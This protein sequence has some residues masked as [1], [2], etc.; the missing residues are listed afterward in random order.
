MSELISWDN[1]MENSLKLPGIKVNRDEYLKDV[2][3]S[4]GDISTLS[5]RRPVDVFG[6]VIIDKVAKASIN[7]HLLGVTSASAAAGIP[8]GFA[9]LGT[10][11]ADLAQYYYHV[12]IIAQKLGY[13]Y[14]WPDLLDEKQQFSE[15]SRNILTLFVGVMLGAGAA[16]KAV[17]E[18]GKKLSMQVA[19]R[20]PQQ[21]LTKTAYYPIIKQVGKWIGM[22]VTKETFAKGASKFIP[23]LGGVLSGGLT[24]FTFKPMA[25]KL[26]AKLKE[27]ANSYN[28]YGSA[29]AQDSRTESDYEDVQYEDFTNGSEEVKINIEFVKIQALIN[30]AK[31]DFELHNQEIEFISNLVEDS[32]LCDDEKMALVGQLH[33]KDL[34]EI[35]LSIFLGND[36]Y[37]LTLI[38]S[39]ASLIKIDGI[40]KS[41]E[42][43]YFYKIARELGFTRDDVSD[44][45]QE[46][47]VPDDITARPV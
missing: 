3:R 21:A 29:G 14:G 28:F 9:M 12:V 17:T 10:V 7:K 33:S 20:L 43:I 34:V 30:I 31:I 44:M 11:P 8:G 19:K 36:L 5:E 23:V 26:H 42:K 18:V 25:N 15:S 22:K 4:Y 32:E 41:V 38:E 24:F 35:D 27:D 40:I 1:L 47:I 2:F 13:I 39:L 37:A 16:N 6:D 45:L 46:E